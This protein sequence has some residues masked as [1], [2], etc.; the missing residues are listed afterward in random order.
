MQP[1]Q[2]DVPDGGLGQSEQVQ[3][4]VVGVTLRR[5]QRGDG[6]SLRSW[7]GFTLTFVCARPHNLVTS[8]SEWIPAIYWIR[9]RP[10]DTYQI[11][12][13][14]DVNGIDGIVGYATG[15]N[16]RAR[17]A[18]VAC[19]ANTSSLARAG[20]SAVTNRLCRSATA[21]LSGC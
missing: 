7:R 8:D 6:G 2:Y 12:D 3:S 14:T 20:K 1:P 15:W 5:G 9:V 10:V 11:Y 18:G 13:R 19:D 17:S 21:G 4:G 16:I